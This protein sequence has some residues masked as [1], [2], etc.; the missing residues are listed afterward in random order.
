MKANEGV[1]FSSVESYNG[2]NSK[3]FPDITVTSIRP[4]HIDTLYIASKHSIN[5]L[6]VNA[7]LRECLSRANNLHSTVLGKP[8]TAPSQK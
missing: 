5:A 4:S 7:Q 8:E 1:L 2:N 6:L 3:S